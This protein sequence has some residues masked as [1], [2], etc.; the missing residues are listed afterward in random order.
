M[1]SAPVTI[2]IGHVTESQIFSSRNE[3]WNAFREKRNVGSS[4]GGA[5]EEDQCRRSQRAGSTARCRKGMPPTKTASWSE[6]DDV[7]D[8]LKYDKRFHW[9]AGKRN[10]PLPLRFPFSRQ[11]KF[12]SARGER[13]HARRSH[14]FGRA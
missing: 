12:R 13:P 3:A 11:R 14:A 7:E 10:A 4:K 8:S 6:I 1:K 5:G 2:L 9:L